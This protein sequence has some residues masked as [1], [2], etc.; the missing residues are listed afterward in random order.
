M[1]MIV[2]IRRHDLHL[3]AS[4]LNKLI[5]QTMMFLATLVVHFS[6]AD[7]WQDRARIDRAKLTVEAME[8][9]QGTILWQN[10]KGRD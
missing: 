5:N 3:L 9:N 4:S 8:W 2:C 7:L 1:R 6:A 10:T